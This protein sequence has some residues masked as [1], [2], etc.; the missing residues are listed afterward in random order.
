MNF[1]V[2][3]LRE[4]VLCCRR[5]GTRRCHE[6]GK[7][8]SISEKREKS[9]KSHRKSFMETFERLDHKKDEGETVKG[10]SVVC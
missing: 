8:M 6:E 10:F 5:P 9:R 7:E 4:E 3:T 1:T 2:V